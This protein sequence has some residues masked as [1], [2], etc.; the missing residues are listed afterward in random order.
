MTGETVEEALRISAFVTIGLLLPQALGYAAYRWSWS[1][2]MGFK[3]LSYLVAPL[4]Y[5]VSANLYWGHEFAIVQSQGHRVCG[6]M[7]MAM[8]ITTTFGTLFHFAAGM[9][10]LLV[11]GWLWKR[12]ARLAADFRR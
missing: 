5:C 2:A 1:K 11:L 8:G 3:V 7:G 9:I 12:R 4:V 10:F 6:A